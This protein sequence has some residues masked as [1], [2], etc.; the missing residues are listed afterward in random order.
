MELAKTVTDEVMTM[1]NRTI[2]TLNAD[3]NRVYLTGYSLGSYGTWTMLSRYD[4]RFA[5]AI[6]LRGGTV[7]SDFV[8]ARLVDTPIL[9]L[10]AHDDPTAPAAATRNVLNSILAAARTAAGIPLGQRSRDFFHVERSRSLARG[11]SR[12]SPSTARAINRF[13]FG[14]PKARSDLL[15]TATRRTRFSGSFQCAAVIRLDVLAHDCCARAHIV[16]FAVHACCHLRIGAAK[17]LS[18]RATDHL[19]LIM[20]TTTS[21]LLSK[22][23]SLGLD[24]NERSM[25]S[26]QLLAQ[27]A[28][29]GHIT[30][31][32]SDR[33]RFPDDLRAA[34]NRRF[35]RAHAI[36]TGQFQSAYAGLVGCQRADHATSYRIHSAIPGSAISCKK[37]NGPD[38]KGGSRVAG[39]ENR[40]GP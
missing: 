1:V 30:L 8:P 14:E 24:E 29:G 33:R 34:G 5:A 26:P 31:T 19:S 4:G 2:S 15:Q 27:L 7:Q 35:Y 3:T 16:R 23:I 11:I 6:P 25:V 10:H 40:S 18:L 13:S 17:T 22:A 36:R 20:P 39:S 38:V 32:P 12:L 21:N 9:T 28:I 37:E